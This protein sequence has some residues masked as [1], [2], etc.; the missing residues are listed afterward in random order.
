MIL[1]EEIKQQV[2]RN[3][4]EIFAELINRVK[5]GRGRAALHIAC[6]CNRV[7]VVDYLM[8]YGADINIRDGNII[9]KRIVKYST[10]H[11][12]RAQSRGTCH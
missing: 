6:A 5:E 4:K 3:I 9:T 10:L 11:R 1:K 7:E 12:S 2:K 8:E